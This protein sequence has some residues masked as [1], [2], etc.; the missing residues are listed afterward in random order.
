MNNKVVVSEAHEVQITPQEFLARIGMPEPPLHKLFDVVEYKSGFR[1]TRYAAIDGVEQRSGG[2]M[3]HG[4]VL[5][6]SGIE[7]VQFM[8]RDVVRVM[9]GDCA[10]EKA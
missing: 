5:M 4:R 7:S 1:G 9:A 10:G 6:M 3:Y 2:W 8:E